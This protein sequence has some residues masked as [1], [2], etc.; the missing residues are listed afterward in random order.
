MVPQQVMRHFAIT[1]VQLEVGSVA[2]D[3]EHRSFGQELA[4][5]QRYYLCKIL[6]LTSPGE[7]R[8]VRMEAYSTGSEY[9]LSVTIP[10]F[11]MRATT[12]TVSS[13]VN[14]NWCCW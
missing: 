1:G 6:L 4:L 5:C 10:R 9:L 3:F 12:V 11:K 8:L 2:T 14:Y 13:G 7:N